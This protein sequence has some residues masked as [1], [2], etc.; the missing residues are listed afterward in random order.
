MSCQVMSNQYYKLFQTLIHT[1]DIISDSSKHQSCE[2]F[3]FSAV[4]LSFTIDVNATSCYLSDVPFHQPNTY[5]MSSSNVLLQK[6]DLIGSKSSSS[7]SS[8]I[9]SF[10]S[11]CGSSV[12]GSYKS[13]ST[14]NGSVIDSY[15]YSSGGSTID[16]GSGE[17]DTNANLKDSTVS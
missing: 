6:H 11:S 4:Y 10:K 8:T 2:C 12:I 14:E 17:F 15:K 7:S 5:Q 16:N 9:G 3:V 13:S 1:L